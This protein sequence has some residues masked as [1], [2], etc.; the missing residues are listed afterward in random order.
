MP[1]RTAFGVFVALVASVAPALA[2][3]VWLDAA[4]DRWHAV[5]TT[6]PITDAPVF[7]AYVVTAAVNNSVVGGNL[8]RVELTCRAGKARLTF[9]WNFKAVGPANLVVDYRFDGR[10][11]RTVKARYVNRTLTETTA[12]ADIRQFLADAAG[13]QSLLVRANSDTYG[14][15]TATFRTGAG[16]DMAAR[17]AAACPAVGR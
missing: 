7:A 3:N 4:S 11:G 17:F 10:A 15:N 8:A 1:V 14:V 6:D 5:S 12:I 9:E 2:G 13:P 16:P